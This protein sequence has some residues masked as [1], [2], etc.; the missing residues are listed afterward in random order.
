MTSTDKAG[1]GG[2][3]WSS[4]KLLWG[5]GDSA[6]NGTTGDINP[7]AGLYSVNI[8]K[9]SKSVVSDHLGMA[10]GIARGKDGSVYASNNL[11]KGAA[12]AGFPN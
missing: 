12:S 3:A 7:T 5:Y 11:G 1:P 4:K 2:L 6:A 9:K 10:N 8:A